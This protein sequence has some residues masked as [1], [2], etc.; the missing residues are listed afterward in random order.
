MTKLTTKFHI[1]IDGGEERIFAAHTSIYSHAV[2][3]AFGKLRLA[4]PCT[5]E[6]WVPDLVEGG[7]GPYTYRIDNFVD[8]HG[9]VYGCPSVMIV[10]RSALQDMG[11]VE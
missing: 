1:R 6:I 5:V 8:Q 10:T 11:G 9:N 4:Y 2:M 7:Y 3:A